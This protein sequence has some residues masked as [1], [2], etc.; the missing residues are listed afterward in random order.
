[1]FGD[2][3][4]LTEIC[5]SVSDLNTCN[6]T[7]GGNLSDFD[8]SCQAEP[9]YVPTYKVGDIPNLVI[10]FFGSTFGAIIGIISLF[11]LGLLIYLISK[12]WR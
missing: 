2:C 3:E 10:D 5:L 12:Y 4:N 9:N 8:Q 1:M 7:F 6:E 11:I